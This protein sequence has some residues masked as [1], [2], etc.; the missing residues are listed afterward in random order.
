MDLK[1]DYSIFQ[2]GIRRY[3]GAMQGIPDRIPVYAQI[4]EYARK[5]IGVSGKEFYTSPELL[6]R[7]SLETMAKWG[8]DFPLID[9]DV[10]NIEAEALGQ[11]IIYYEDSIP[12]IDRSLPLIRDRNDLKKIKTPDFNFDGR[13]SNVVEQGVLFHK[14]TGIE[15]DLSFC[16]PFTLAANIRGVEQLIT[17]IMVD[18]DFAKELLDRVTEE[19][20]IPWILYLKVKFPR[21]TAICGSD[22]MSSLPIVNIDIL[23][24]WSLP[25]ILRLQKICGPEV[26]VPNWVG[27]RYLNNPD[28]M[29][30]LKLQACPYFLQGQDPD[31]SEI[32]PE[33]YKS[34]ADKADV[35]LILGIGAS[36]LSQSTTCNIQDRVKQ[37]IE[38]A[39]KNGRFCLYLCNI[40]HLTP[41]K[42]LKAAIDAIY[43]FGS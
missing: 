16:A 29:F 40:D 13:L 34:Y 35:P 2:E 39:G 8:I 12:D 28:E 22:A 5:E 18:P 3:R 4:L 20:L 1:N 42:N 23:R 43:K 36:F 26:Y 15:P 9:Y 37:Y 19:V 24:K 33:A 14:L 25:Y 21:S 10:Y 27:E 32:G 30:D 7:G 31:V 6:V 38:I 11:K 41:H 17:D